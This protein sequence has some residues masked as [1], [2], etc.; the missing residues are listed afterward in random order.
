MKL[1]SDKPWFG[2]ISFRMKASQTVK[3]IAESLLKAVELKD[4]FTADHCRRV[5]LGAEKLAQIMGLSK[6]ECT[7][8]YY[9]GLFHDIGKVGIPD[10]IL[11]KP[12]KLTEEEFHLM[13]DHAEMSVQILT[14][15]TKKDL[16]FRSLIP[17]VRYHHEKFDGSGYPHRLKGEKIPLAARVISVVDTYDAM[18]NVRPYRQALDETYVLKELRDFSGRQFDP[19]I[20]DTFIANLEEWKSVSASYKKAA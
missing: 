20:V 2:P 3:S 17:G 18:S 11:L 14:P 13:R 9:A 8:I 19:E 12:A 1:A 6:E 16:F 10:S 15:F 5:G 4:H 7:I